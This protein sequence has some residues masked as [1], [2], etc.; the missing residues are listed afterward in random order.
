M[1]AYTFTSITK[2]WRETIF[3]L[4]F[5]TY[6]KPKKQKKTK[7]IDF[8]KL[9]CLKKNKHT[10]EQEPVKEMKKTR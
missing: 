4:V 10:T 1:K 9:F 3:L 6:P 2:I 8:V 7:N 5:G